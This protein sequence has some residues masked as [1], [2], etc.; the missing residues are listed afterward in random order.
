MGSE[1][2][3]QEPILDQKVTII[4]PA[5]SPNQGSEFTIEGAPL[6]L[7]FGLMFLRPPG[8]NEGDIQIQDDR[9]RFWALRVWSQLS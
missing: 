8:P 4:R 7:E 9:L 1:A 3:T 5:N 6:I 2:A